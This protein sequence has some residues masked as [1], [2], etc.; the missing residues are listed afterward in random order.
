[1]RRD[2]TSNE[3]AKYRNEKAKLDLDAAKSSFREEYFDASVNRSYYA[4]LH[5]TRALLALER[6][7]FKSTQQ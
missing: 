3:L 7:D 2:A 1:M 5:A 4:I 6:K